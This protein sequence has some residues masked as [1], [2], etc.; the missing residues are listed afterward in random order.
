MILMTGVGGWRRSARHAKTARASATLKLGLRRMGRM[1]RGATPSTHPRTYFTVTGQAERTVAD[2][3][4]ASGKPGVRLRRS[5]G[6]EAAVGE[7]RVR[8]FGVAGRSGAVSC[9]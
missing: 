6:V 7:R 4:P 5:R 3:A 2:Q 9:S 8:V 1:E